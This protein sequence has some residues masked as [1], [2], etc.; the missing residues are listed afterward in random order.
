METTNSHGVVSMWYFVVV[1]KGNEQGRAWQAEESLIE[2][3][4]VVK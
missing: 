2:I 4:V 1:L 3:E